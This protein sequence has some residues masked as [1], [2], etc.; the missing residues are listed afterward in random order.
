M[1]SSSKVTGTSELYANCADF[2]CR[3][4]KSSILSSKIFDNQILLNL[5]SHVRF[6]L[7]QLPQTLLLEP[8]REAPLSYATHFIPTLSRSFA[9]PTAL[10]PSTLQ[11]SRRSTRLKPVIMEWKSGEMQL[12]IRDRTAEERRSVEVTR[13]RSELFGRLISR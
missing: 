10:E 13:T 6:S 4:V 5:H 2:T 7:F 11:P 3:L 9:I 1:I 12:Q 8:H